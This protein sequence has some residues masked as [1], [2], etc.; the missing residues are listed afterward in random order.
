MAQFDMWQFDQETRL[1]ALGGALCL[2]ACFVS[3]ILM[4]H[5]RA[6]GVYRPRMTLIAALVFGTGLSATLFA[7][8]LAYRPGIALRYQLAATLLSVAAAMTIGWFA[9]AVVLH[10]RAADAAIAAG[11][12]PVASAIRH[13]A[14]FDRLGDVVSQA[15]AAAWHGRGKC[16]AFAAATLLAL[17][18]C[19]L[20]FVAVRD[21]R[22]AAKTAVEKPESTSDAAA[23]QPRG[24]SRLSDRE[25][26][27]RMA[28]KFV[29][30][31]RD[32]VE[33][34][35]A[36]DI[37]IAALATEIATAQNIDPLLVLAVIATESGFQSDAVSAGNA[38]GLMQLMPDT[39]RRFGVR[40][41]LNPAENIRAGTRYLRWLLAH[42]EGD[43]SL[44]LAAYNAGEGAV[45]HYGG[46]PPFPETHAYLRK[47]RTL[48][49]AEHHPIDQLAVH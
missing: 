34:R 49:P 3:L 20:D 7:F 22:P 13:A 8:M 39:A 48:Y 18:I 25:R 5:A 33:R 10:L 2:I 1:V 40:D 45:T 16:R 9:L 47:I 15:M 21:I 37:D 17:A 31:A 24:P 42:F 29:A 28:A 38:Q 43:L 36:R 44:A 23:M 4:I 14:E 26:A 11:R 12:Y 19:G 46:V 27:V 35:E 6:G 30:T 32:P 41:L